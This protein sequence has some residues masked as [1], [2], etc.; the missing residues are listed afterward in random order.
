ML[1]LLHAVRCDEHR[2][3][4]RRTG[5]AWS[6]EQNMAHTGDLCTPF[7]GPMWWPWLSC[8]HPEV[9]ARIRPC[10]FSCWPFHL[11]Q[12]KWT[13]CL[14]QLTPHAAAACW[15]AKSPQELQDMVWLPCAH[16]WNSFAAYEPI[17]AAVAYRKN[18]EQKPCCISVHSA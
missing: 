5:I 9:A 15:S 2:W 18:L 11:I 4:Q 17:H 10:N 14:N 12:Q 8:I 3:G 6:Q 1:F 13:R 7:W 16:R